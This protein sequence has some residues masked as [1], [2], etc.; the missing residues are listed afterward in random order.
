[1]EHWRTL[2]KLWTHGKHEQEKLF[3]SFFFLHVRICHCFVQ[4]HTHS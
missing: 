1:M 3:M 4:S 2:H